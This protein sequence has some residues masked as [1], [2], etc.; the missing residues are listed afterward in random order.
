MVELHILGDGELVGLENGNLSDCTPYHEKR[1]KTYSGQ[2]IGY[3]RRI[4]N[5]MISVEAKADMNGEN[6]CRLEIN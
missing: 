5:G 1:R 4:G 6:C 2:L 3:V